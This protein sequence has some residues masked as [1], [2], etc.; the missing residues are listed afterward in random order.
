MNSIRLLTFLS[1]IFS[2]AVYAA[3][4]K[5]TS[6][7][8]ANALK[9]NKR[10]VWAELC[11]NKEISV[12]STMTIS[13]SGATLDGSG[14]MIMKW[15]GKHKCDE[16]PSNDA[17]FNVTGSNNKLKNF[18]LDWSP[19]G[20]H[21][22]G[23]GNTVDKVTWIKICEDG[24]TNYGKNNT[25]QNSLFQ[26]APDKC[27]QTNGGTATFL[28]NTFKKCPRS[29]GSCS[30]K[31]DP[32]NHPTA[33]CKVPSFNTVVGNKFYGC[34]NY[35]IRTSGKKS[36]NA[37]GWLKASDN[38][39]YDCNGAMQSEEDGDLYARN[40]RVI[41]GTAFDTETRYGK[42]SGEIRECKT[43]L[44]QGAKYYT[45]TKPIVDCNWD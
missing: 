31:A 32:G 9:N 33:N 41:K 5:C 43:S 17:V 24:L 12:S 16:K 45:N 21:L 7:T 34:S 37:N 8:I 3:P 10:F 25:I 13:V 18:S 2:Y 40:N 4:G 11:T 22:R 20:I 1:V 15:T 6:S 36:K 28:N 35:A 44:E 19:E 39:F 23:N 29:I 30:D 42:F 14:Q 38:E 26:N 27:V